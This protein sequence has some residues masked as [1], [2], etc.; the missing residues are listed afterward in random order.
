MTTD[1]ITAATRISERERAER[2]RETLDRVAGGELIVIERDGR[3][4]AIL[5]PPLSTRPIRTWGDFVHWLQHESLFD[6]EFADTVRELRK[7]QPPVRWA[8]WP[9]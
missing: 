4:I 3:A 9:E 6:E 5:E 7:F 8:E 2:L 1:V